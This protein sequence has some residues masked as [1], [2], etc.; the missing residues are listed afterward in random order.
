MT[1]A[2]PRV[3]VSSDDGTL[4]AEYPW[5]TYRFLFEDGATLDV[6][7][8]RDDSDLR[9]AMLTLHYGRKVSDPRQGRIEGVAVI[10]EP[11]PEARKAPAKRVTRRN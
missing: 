5:H 11:Q 6:V 9:E 10:P 7:A 2:K 3:V 8:I 1:T 4:R